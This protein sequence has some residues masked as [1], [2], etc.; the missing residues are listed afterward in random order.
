MR[1]ING[2]INGKCVQLTINNCSELR[3]N[4]I[5][6]KNWQFDPKTEFV[7]KRFESKRDIEIFF[8]NPI[9]NPLVV[10]FHNERPIVR[11]KYS[12]RTFYY[13]WSI[14]RWKTSDYD[15]YYYSESIRDFVWNYVIGQDGS[16]IKSSYRTKTE[17]I[18]ALME[19]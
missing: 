2:K 12:G 10:D 9:L 7:S 5:K 13:N 3:P 6:R 17:M 19:L 14:G 16:I 4:V 1:E 18:S 11:V 15:Q 8:S